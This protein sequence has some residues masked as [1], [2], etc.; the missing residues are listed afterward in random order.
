MLVKTYADI[1]R[2]S[3][4]VRA[5]AYD[6]LLVVGASLLI[7]LS[8]FVLRVPLGGTPVP[9][10]GQTFAVLFLSMLLGAKRAPAAVALYLFSGA[11]GL[12]F[13]S[14]GALAG[15]TGG[16]LVGFFFAAV[17]VGFL[18]EQGMDKKHYTT[19][20]AMVIGN[21][22][23]Y[24][25]GLLWLSL[26]VGDKVCIMGLFPYIPGDLFKIALAAGLLPLGWKLKEKLKR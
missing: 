7:S 12:P 6:V 25:F 11:A 8:N 16:Y 4:R 21:I 19:I 10:T 14:G 15:P 5:F 13:Y 17:V 18:A 2:P 1:L 22:I 3:A 24:T 26:Y 20:V 23:L 9:I